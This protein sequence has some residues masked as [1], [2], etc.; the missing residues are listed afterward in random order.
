MKNRKN[1]KRNYMK[2][3]SVTILALTLV[4]VS[5]SKLFITL[6]LLT[7]SLEPQNICL[8]QTTLILSLPMYVMTRKFHPSSLDPSCSLL[9]IRSSTPPE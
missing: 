9:S 6:V 4:V 2:P 3:I 7:Y 8:R 1:S 5:H